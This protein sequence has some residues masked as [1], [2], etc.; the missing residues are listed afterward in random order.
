M[1]AS[2]QALAYIILK[3]LILYKLKVIFDVFFFLFEGG[4]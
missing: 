4:E 1:P 3:S 2:N